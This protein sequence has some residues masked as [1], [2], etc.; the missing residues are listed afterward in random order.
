MPRPT[1]IPSLLCTSLLICLSAGR[2]QPAAPTPRP[3]APIKS[4]PEDPKPPTISQRVGEMLKG[5]KNSTQAR[6]VAAALDEILDEQIL[7]ID[8]KSTADLELTCAARRL[9][10]QISLIK[11]IEASAA[12][13]KTLQT[14][15]DVADALAW[16]LNPKI[17]E[18][19][20][21]YGV[22]ATLSARFDSR[23]DRY[24]TLVAALCIV[25]DS[26]RTGG[27]K[28]A[29]PA[30]LF[31]FFVTNERSMMMPIAG[32]STQ[33]LTHIVDSTASVQE[34]AWALPQHRRD[35]RIGT[36]YFDII[37]DTPAFT[38]GKPKKIVGHP[39]TLQNILKYGGVCVE[40]AYYAEHIAKAIGVPSVTVSGVGSSVGHAWVGYMHFAGR[41]TAWDFKEGRYDEY[42]GARGNVRDPQSGR[43]VSDGF[44]ALRAEAAKLGPAPFKKAAALADCAHR[45]RERIKA[46]A[47]DRG[48]LPSPVSVLE[49]AANACPYSTTTWETV[50]AWAKEGELDAPALDRWCQAVVKLCG[51]KYPDFAYETLGPIIDSAKDPAARDRLWTW[52]RKNLLDTV[53]NPQ[54]FRS[55]LAARMLIDCGDAWREAGNFNLAWQRYNRVVIEN[56]ND[57]TE[58]FEAAKC[59]EALMV[60]GGKSPAEIAEYLR[61]SWSRIRKPMGM[62]PQFLGM[63]NWSRVGKLYASWLVK[64]GR[65]GEAD[66]L[67]AQLNPPTVGR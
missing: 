27:H 46:A 9:V 22:L 12:A 17:D 50:A 42:K 36:H 47:G 24:A 7:K 26:P 25:H 39:Y 38:Q 62:S 11:D 14:H 52:A 53:T 2:A 15:P 59:C 63:S 55:D 67:Q 57:T 65:K 8:P 49:L 51:D 5:L 30:E 10:R 6:Q 23:L 54:Y 41:A 44:I 13:V 56:A 58:M 37:Y 33:L 40:Q 16:S 61:V 66:S 18:T 28:P 20:A 32:G 29:S 34:L 4:A 64:A 60:A 31:E 45:L 35:D 1:L 19:A 48:N 43:A 3:A 21:A